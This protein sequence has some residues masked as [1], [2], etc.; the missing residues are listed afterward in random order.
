MSET[1]ERIG[2][3]AK[4]GYH[5]VAT[6]LRLEL[7]PAFPRRL[8]VIVDANADPRARRNGLGVSLQQ[9]GFRAIPANTGAGAIISEAEKP[10]AGVLSMPGHARAGYLEDLVADAIPANDVLRPRAQECATS[11]PHAERRFAQLHYLKAE[12]HTWLA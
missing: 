8:A 1:G 7:T 3:K 6:H 12:V 4:N 10:V 9:A 5:D 11:I 2:L